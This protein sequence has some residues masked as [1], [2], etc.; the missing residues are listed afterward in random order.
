MARGAGCTAEAQA[1]PRGGASVRET[2]VLRDLRRAA[3]ALTPDEFADSPQTWW[4]GTRYGK[5]LAAVE[6]SGQGFHV[7]SYEAA[8]QA[9]AAQ[10]G[11]D[12]G[13]RE[14][15]AERQEA[16]RA[17]LRKWAGE[18]TAN[19]DGSYTYR[20]K[21]LAGIGDSEETVRFDGDY[22]DLVAYA[23]QYDNGMVEP[24]AARYAA[25]RAG[26]GL[27]RAG[28]VS[29]DPPVYPVVHRGSGELSDKGADAQPDGKERPVLIPV[30]IV[31]EMTNAPTGGELRDDYWAN[32]VMAS[33]LRRNRARRGMY[34]KNI[35]EDEGS[36]SAVLPNRAGVCTHADFIAEAL[37]RGEPV[38][39]RVLACYPQ[40][41]ENEGS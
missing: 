38:P 15:G 40:L 3:V 2:G 29:L 11:W 12:L 6:T 4:H 20:T 26:L 19:P 37:R 35:S 8:R 36:V 16:A 28:T 39:E 5:L 24:W 7:G 10:C 41:A 27:R 9:L 25:A 13:P 34:Y 22:L 33:N 17:Y 23:R 30:W 31:G 18:E 14:Q 1:S 32:G 21:R